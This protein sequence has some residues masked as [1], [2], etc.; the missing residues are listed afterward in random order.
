MDTPHPLKLYTVRLIPSQKDRLLTYSDWYLSGA[1]I[2]P[3]PKHISR[4]RHK[5]V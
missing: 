3:S 1:S 4:T 5:R 2:H